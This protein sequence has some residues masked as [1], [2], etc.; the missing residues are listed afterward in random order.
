MTH[1]RKNSTDQFHKG[2]KMHIVCLLEKC[3]C[4]LWNRRVLVDRSSLLLFYLFPHE[5]KASSFLGV[6]KAVFLA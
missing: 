4:R 3:S 1:Y 5:S 6:R 2:G